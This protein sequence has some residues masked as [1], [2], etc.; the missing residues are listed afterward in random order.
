ML[1]QRA[2]YALRAMMVLAASPNE[3]PM[4]TA[5]IADATNISRKFLEAILLELRKAG[6]LTS[7]RGCR[8]GFQLARPSRH[9]SFADIVRVTDGSLA[10]APCA[11][12][13]SS[14]M[15][16]DCEGQESCQIRAALLQ[17]RKNADEVLQAYDLAGS[18][19]V[20]SLRDYKP[21]SA[22]SRRL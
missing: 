13:F 15:C 6:L 12:E 2:R 16:D 20:P 7:R 3:S 1:S 5:E 9:I 22:P 17:A 21:V 19:V 11:N 10:L 4:R 8:G 18:K 14:R